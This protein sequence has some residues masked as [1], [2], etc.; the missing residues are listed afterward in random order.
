[1]KTYTIRKAEQRDVAGIMRLLAQVA[2]VHHKI[3]PDLFKGGVTKYT[4]EELKA[5]FCEPTTPVFV[6]EEEGA[7]LGHAFCQIK[8]VKDSI[9]FCDRKTFY[10]DDICVDENARRKGVGRAIYEFVLAYAK[11]I[12]CDYLTLNVYKA[13][14]SAAGFYRA[15]GMEERNIVME[16][17]L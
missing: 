16:C 8:E 1:M 9:L 2:E 7:I 6:C 13:N 5:I 17:K 15:M 11:E 14:E 10:I 12:G 3:R 4:E